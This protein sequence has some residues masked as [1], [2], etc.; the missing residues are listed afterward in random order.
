MVKVSAVICELNPMHQGH[1]YI[2]ERAKENADVLVAVMSGNYVQRGESAIFD[3]YTRARA[4][5]EGGVDLVIELPFPYCSASAEFFAEAGV[6]L[7]EL[8]GAQELFF[9]SECA[10]IDALKRAAK[11]LEDR[12]EH[13]SGRAA[14]DREETL[15]ASG[16]SFP[17][18][19][20]SSPNDILATEYVRRAS[21]ECHPVKRIK[22]Q[23]ASEIRNGI[24]ARF[25]KDGVSEDVRNEYGAAPVCFARL[26]EIEFYHF[27]TVPACG[28]FAES[29][30]G[31][32][33]RLIKAA[34]SVNDPALWLSAA[35]TKQYTNARLRR[36]ALFETCA[37]TA[38]ALR[39]PPGFLRVLAANRTGRKYLSFLRGSS[40]VPVLTN[41]A[42][43]QRLD[44][45]AMRQYRES[46]AADRLYTLCAGI[47]DSSFFARAR[48]FVEK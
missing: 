12:R 19:I 40:S 28:H 23:S 43:R 20:Y 16:E 11:I 34:R 2:F 45:A 18:S 42:D 14:A 25:S 38:G 21:I 24:L 39:E 37:V 3:K 9:G 47:E 48:P 6:R 22:T 1:R 10:D 15:R 13:K 36:C 8:S 17:E 27:R 31:V 32:G 7:A 4:A 29:G 46:D 5:L 33:E 30:G 26:T 35:A 41:P 44:E